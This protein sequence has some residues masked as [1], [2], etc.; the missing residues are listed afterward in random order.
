MEVK[1]MEEKKSVKISL[2]TLFLILALIV[3]AFMAYYIYTEKT[4]YNNKIADLES[5]ID[6][7]T[8]TSIIDNEKN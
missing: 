2:S 5:K 3:I 4:T 1:R 7:I 8:S 6:N